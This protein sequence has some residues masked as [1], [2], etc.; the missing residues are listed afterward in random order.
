MNKG[1]IGSM[2]TGQSFPH[3]M[4]LCIVYTTWLACRSGNHGLIAILKARGW[5]YFLLC[6]I[7]VEANVL[8]SV[9]HQ[10]TSVASIQVRDLIVG[11]NRCNDGDVFF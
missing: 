6:L 1:V 8:T 3:Y 4:F 11:V 10:F 7:D 5:R 9:S 2:P